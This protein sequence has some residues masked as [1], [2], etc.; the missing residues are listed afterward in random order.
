MAADHI[1]PR[2]WPARS[3]SLAD[4]ARAAL[5]RVLRAARLDHGRRRA[6]RS[7]RCWARSTDPAGA[8]SATRRARSCC[9]SAP[10][11]PTTASRSSRAYHARPRRRC[12]TRSRTSGDARP[13]LYEALGWTVRDTDE[14]EADD[15]LARSPRPRPRRAAA[16]L[17][18]TGDRD[19]FQC[20]TRPVTV[21]L[22]R[23][24]P[25]RGRTRSGRPRCASATASPPRRCP[26]SS[27]CAATRPTGSPGAKGIGEK[28][29]ADLLRRARLARG[30]DRSGAIAR[31]ARRV[32]ARAARRRP[33]SCAP[34]RTSRRCATREVER[35]PDAPTDCAG[36][37]PRP[38]ASSA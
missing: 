2:A 12:P 36:A 23:A 16:T 15:L 21:L 35:P 34:S 38:R 5:P 20:A 22:Q 4:A 37:A 26:T 17:I 33:T 25:A 27:R 6:A 24:R 9:A 1:L 3:L 7:T 18:L 13:A 14:L 30:R 10:R 11:R 19:L 29:A 31:D 28:T 32:R 8:S